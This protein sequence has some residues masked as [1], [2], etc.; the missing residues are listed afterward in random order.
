MVGAPHPFDPLTGDEIAK[1]VDLV[2]K[3]HGEQF[4]QAVTLLEPRKS[5]MVKWLENQ[6]SAPRPHRVADVTTIAPGG[7]VYDGLV[8]LETGK[9]TSWEQLEGVQPIVRRT[10]TQRDRAGGSLCARI[11]D[12]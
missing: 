11:A 1:A 4:F 5:E 3:T 9:I 6:A 2:K 12:M 10:I 7:K 8:D